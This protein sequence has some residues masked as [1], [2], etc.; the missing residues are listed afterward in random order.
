MMGLSLCGVQMF[1]VSAPV[2]AGG[3]LSDPHF[4]KGAIIKQI[5]T[6]GNLKNFCH[7]YLPVADY[8][9][10][11][12]RF[13]KLKYGFESSISNVGFGFTPAIMDKIFETNS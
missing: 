10:C 6:R 7:R 12:K 9:S 11:Q 3:Q 4:E 13:I 2:T 1:T 5:N 8:V